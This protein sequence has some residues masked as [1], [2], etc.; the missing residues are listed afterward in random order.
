M[1]IPNKEARSKVLY[2]SGPMTGYPELNYPAFNEAEI[3][4]LKEGWSVEN[5]ASIGVVEGAEWED[6]MTSALLQISKCGA[7]YMLKGWQM[8]RGACLE[9]LIAQNLN[10]KIIYEDA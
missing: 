4:L 10:F 8:S 1:K 7:M 2:L 6:Y 3:K 5:P 9:Q